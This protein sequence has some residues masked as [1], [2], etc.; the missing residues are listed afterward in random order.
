MLLFYGGCGGCIKEVG[1]VLGYGFNMFG[2][3]VMEGGCISWVMKQR[4]I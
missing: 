2:L 1:C 3:Y 4:Y